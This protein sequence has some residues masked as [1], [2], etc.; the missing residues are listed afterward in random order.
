MEFFDYGLENDPVVRK[1]LDLNHLLDLKY[2][3]NF[4]MI[5]HFVFDFSY[6]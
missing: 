4:S 6:F 2:I 1:I 5:L 3:F